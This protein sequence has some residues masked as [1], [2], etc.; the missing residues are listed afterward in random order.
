MNKAISTSNQYFLSSSCSK[1]IAPDRKIAY[2]I[3][4]NPN[5]T[6]TG[7]KTIKFGKTI[8]LLKENIFGEKYINSCIK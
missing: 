1:R 2:L 7:S 8:N 4:Q 3:G 6:K 5:I